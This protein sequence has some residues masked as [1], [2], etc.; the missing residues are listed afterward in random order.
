MLLYTLN[1]GYLNWMYV[2]IDIYVTHD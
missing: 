1:G 2:A